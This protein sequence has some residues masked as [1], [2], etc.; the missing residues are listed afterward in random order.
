LAL[1]RLILRHLALRQG[2]EMFVISYL[3]LGTWL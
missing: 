3:T 2:I 1:R